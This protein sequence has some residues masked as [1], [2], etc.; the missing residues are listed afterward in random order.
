MKLKIAELP[1]GTKWRQIWAL[2]M[3]AGIGFTM[4][5]FIDSLAFKDMDLVNL[6]KATIL[7]TSTLAAVLGLLAM[8]ITCK[9]ESN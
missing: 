7:L 4:S 9:K 3:I 6:G 5:I 2:G 8:F 1:Q